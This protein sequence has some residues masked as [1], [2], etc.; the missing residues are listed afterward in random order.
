MKIGIFVKTE[1]G[2]IHSLHVHPNETVH[3]LKN[4]IENVVDIL[5]GKV[6]INVYWNS[7]PSFPGLPFA[8]TG[9]HPELFFERKKLEDRKGLTTDYGICDQCIID[10]ELAE[11]YGELRGPRAMRPKAWGVVLFDWDG[12]MKVKYMLYMNEGI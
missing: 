11:S 5:P 12:E 1:T 10:V 4:L 8:T 7:V 3:G 9:Y 6:L 2:E